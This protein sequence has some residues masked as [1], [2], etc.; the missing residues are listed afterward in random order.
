[1]PLHRAGAIQPVRQ[2]RPAGANCASGGSKVSSGLDANANG[3]LD[4]GE[5]TST[6]Y[7]CNG[8]TGGTGPT[9]PGVIWVDVTGTSA[10]AVSNTGYLANNTAQVTI[11]LP[12]SPAVGD[13]VRVSGVGTGGWKIAQNAGQSIKTQSITGNIGAVWT[14]RDSARWWISVASS[15][16]GSKLAVVASGGQIYTSV[17]TAI[18]STTAGTTGSISESQYDAVELQFIGNNTFTVLSYAGYL[19]VR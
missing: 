3:T 1:M 2:G 7:V 13:I 9:G 17:P 5:I 8:T 15:S 16:D 10:Q 6:T 4:A 19:D 11:T 18:Q 12:A 14:A